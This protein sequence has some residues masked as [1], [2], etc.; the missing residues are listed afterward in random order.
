MTRE[1][2]ISF[3]RRCTNRQMDLQQGLLCS[4]TSKPAEFSE[5]CPN[6]AEDTSVPLQSFS[7][8]PET[9]LELEAQLSEEA[10]AQLKAD[11]NYPLAF[12]TAGV[13]G[14]IG[15]VLWG[16]ITVASG[17]QI[18]YMALAIGAA[19]GL[20][21]RYLGKGVEQKFGITGGVVAVLSC[22][23]GNFLSMIG[24]IAADQGLGLMETLWRFNY[25]ITFSMLAETFSF[26]DVLFYAIAAYEGYKLSFRKFTARELDG[27]K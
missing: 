13:V 9:P 2:Q 3:C 11:Q 18:G 23:L 20:S 1:Q 4:I 27:L 22:L 24:F 8:E 16:A 25:S 5:E 15:A 6:Y 14:V 7:P 19:V 17:Y 26:I 21:M 10:I 12:L